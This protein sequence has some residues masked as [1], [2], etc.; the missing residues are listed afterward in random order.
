MALV[1]L[2]LL[3]RTLAAAGLRYLTAT[4]RKIGRQLRHHLAFDDGGAARLVFWL[5]LLLD[6]VLVIAVVVLLALRWGVPQAEF[7]R[8]AGV[9]VRGVNIGSFTLSLVDIATTSVAFLLLLT[10]VRLRAGISRQPRAAADPAP[11]S[12]PATPSLPVSAMSVW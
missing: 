7:G 9:L 11:T 8:F 6:A 4:E 1:S 12:A 10:L 5:L 3:L 2:A